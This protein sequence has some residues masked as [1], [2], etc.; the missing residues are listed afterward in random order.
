[1]S[2]LRVSAFTL[3]IDGFGAGPDQDLKEPLGVG[4]EAL[5]NW[6]FGTR[7]FRNMSGEDRGTTD[8]E[9]GFV[10]RSFENVG[11]WIMGRNMFGPI[12]GPWRDESW[13][14]WWGDNPPYHV[15]VF[16]L[17]HHPRNPIV[18]EGGT[19]FYFVTDGIHSALEKA[20]AAA[21]GKDV[22][23]GGG[24]AT[25]RQYLQERL[26]DDMHLAISPMLLGSGE[27]LFAGI[28]MLKLG[29]RCTEQV[30]TPNATHLI[31]KRD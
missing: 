11:A 12:R 19:T 4:G 26:I 18:M 7:T 14:G 17:T 13:K 3:S 8:T 21:D 31:I 9:D 10:A 23:L 5:H 25:I 24:V 30:A 2:K 22:R 28:D 1:M 16:V 27:N 6:M 29:Y 15:P 20:K